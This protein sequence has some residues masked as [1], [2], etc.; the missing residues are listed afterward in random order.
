MIERI[1]NCLQN[2]Y[3]AFIVVGIIVL[4]VLVMLFYHKYEELRN[5]DEKDKTLM[6]LG[7]RLQSAYFYGAFLSIII[8]C[9]F[10]LYYRM[11]GEIPNLFS[12]Q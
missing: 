6:N 5:D 3:D 9:L 12:S 8:M 2:D 11:T 7:G 4:S 10:Y 1:I